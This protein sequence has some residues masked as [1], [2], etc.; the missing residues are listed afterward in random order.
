MPVVYDPNI[1]KPWRKAAYRVIV[2]GFLA[3][4]LVVKHRPT[5]SGS[6]NIPSPPFVVVAN[7]L[8]NEDPPL[9]AVAMGCPIAFIAKQ[10]LYNVPI[11]RSLILFL[12]AISIDRAKPDVST[13]K[14]VKEVCRYGWSLGMFIEGTRSKTPGTLGVP[15]EGPAYFAWVLKA[16]IVP[17]GILGTDRAWG[18]AYVRIG[19]PL[20]PERDLE[21]TTWEIMKS[22]SELTGFAMPPPSLRPAR[23]VLT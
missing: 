2:L 11:L 19:K 21:K 18:K 22:L 17:V 8:S 1:I 20:Q 15:Y 4:L 10:E 16:P 14:A 7:H 12:G 6:E 23:P 13:F 3:P 9:V 5:I